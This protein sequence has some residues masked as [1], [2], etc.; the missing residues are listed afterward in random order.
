MGLILPS[1]LVILSGSTCLQ[2][3]LDL[4]N[5]LCYLILFP[6]GSVEVV[7]WGTLSFSSNVTDGLVF[8]SILLLDSG[9][10]S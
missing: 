9:T 7:N 3:T 4:K 8:E 2:Y 1:F 5:L 10:V 6:C